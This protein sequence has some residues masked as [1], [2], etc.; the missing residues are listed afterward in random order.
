M[1]ECIL[2]QMNIYADGKFNKDAAKT[3]LVNAAKA[4]PEMKPVRINFTF[5]ITHYLIK[6]PIDH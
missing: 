1:S 3:Y 5:Y 2:K 6:F 4:K